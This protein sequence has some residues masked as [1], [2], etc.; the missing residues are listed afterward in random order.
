MLQLNFDPFPVL[1]TNRL[2]LRSLREADEMEI[3]LLRSDDSINKY[4]DRV[5]ARSVEDAQQFIRRINDAVSNN[6]S[7][8]WAITLK[9]ETTLAG[10]ISLWNIDKEISQAEIGY[11]LLPQ[12]QGKGV[13]Q[14]ALQPVLAFAFEQMKLNSIVACVHEQNVASVKVL[15]RNK[16]VMT[17]GNE[18]QIAGIVD[19]MTYKLFR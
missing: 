5:K 1:Q 2:L 12:Y 16:F 13:M 9:Y 19:M 17:S 4:L 18:Q 8:F 10:T 6:E 14:E 15:E 3:F 11:E 7:M